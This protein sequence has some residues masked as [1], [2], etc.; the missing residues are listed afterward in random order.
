MLN[1]RRYFSVYIVILCNINNLSNKYFCHKFALNQTSL[2]ILFNCKKTCK[3]GDTQECFHCHLMH[4]ISHFAYNQVSIVC[5]AHYRVWVIMHM[6]RLN[7]LVNFVLSPI[8]W[9]LRSSFIWKCN[10]CVYC[11]QNSLIK[12]SQTSLMK[13]LTPTCVMANTTVIQMIPVFLF[14]FKVFVKPVWL[15]RRQSE[16]CS[17][18]LS[19]TCNWAKERKHWL[20][21]SFNR[22]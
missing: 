9:R 3:T 20:T 18:C 6:T 12:L 19:M 10:I 22:F 8:Y 17:K 21:I 13:L 15:C 14:F 11:E 4:F 1:A 7:R 2:M 5:F 16:R